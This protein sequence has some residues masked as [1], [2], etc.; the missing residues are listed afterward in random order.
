MKK[1]LTLLKYLDQSKITPEAVMEIA[2]ILK[3]SPT[4]EQAAE[5]ANAFRTRGLAGLTVLIPTI[6]GW[7]HS[8]NESSPEDVT[9]TMILQCPHC[10]RL[11]EYGR[12][13]N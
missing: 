11:V 1:F 5:V 9:E 3:R 10:G 8:E 12:T 4:M 13:G 7:P 2:A 6:L